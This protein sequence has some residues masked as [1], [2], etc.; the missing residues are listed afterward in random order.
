ML[1][2]GVRFGEDCEEIAQNLSKLT[3]DP[4][5]CKFLRLILAD[6]PAGKHR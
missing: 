2:A 3:G 4:A 5:S 6:Q 1:G